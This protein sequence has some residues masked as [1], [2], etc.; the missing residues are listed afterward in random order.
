MTAIIAESGPGVQVDP[1]NLQ[2]G[3]R[4]TFRL[5]S[6]DLTKGTYSPLPNSGFMTTDTGNLAGLL[7]AQS[8]A[9][10]AQASTNGKTYTVSTSSRGT[11]YTALY[12]VTPVQGRVSGVIQDSNGVPVQFAVVLF[13]DSSVT[14]IGMTTATVTGAFNGSVPLSGTRFNLQP[15]SL[16][17]SRY[18]LA[19]T[20]GAGSYGPLVVGCNAPLPGLSSGQVS[21]LTAP[22]IVAAVSDVNGAQNAPP[23]PPSCSP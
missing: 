19:F 12:A 11:T 8:G 15:A 14:Q 5:V 4:I 18:Y 17:S 21:A 23:T 22:V 10:L 1:T 20:Y 2:V 7:T 6:I 9:Y 13:F 3:D 16:N